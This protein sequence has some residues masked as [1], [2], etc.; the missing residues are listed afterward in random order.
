MPNPWDVN[1]N[2]QTAT[3]LPKSTK[4]PW[5]VGYSFTA[6]PEYSAL[7]SGTVD[8]VESAIGLG[9]EL[10]ATVR[11]LSGEA[12]DYSSAIAQSRAELDAFES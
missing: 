1:F 4:N 6:D 10:D 11:V 3:S 12:A 9:D 8:F 7:R 5:D 2:K